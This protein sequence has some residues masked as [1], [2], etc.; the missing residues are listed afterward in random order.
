MTGTSPKEAT[1]L[2][3]VLLAETYPLEDI[4]LRMDC[5]VTYYNLEKNM[6]INVKE[7]WVEYGLWLPTDVER[8]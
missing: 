6:I 2:K 8:S 1:E 3:K 5:V 4:C 7:Q